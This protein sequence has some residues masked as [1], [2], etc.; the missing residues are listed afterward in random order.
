MT[1]VIPRK[2]RAIACMLAHTRAS[3]GRNPIKPLYIGFGPRLLQNGVQA[4]RMTRERYAKMYI[5]HG[6]GGVPETSA[7]AHGAGKRICM[8]AEVGNKA[9][10]AREYWMLT[11]STM[12]PSAPA[13]KAIGRNIMTDMAMYNVRTMGEKEAKA[14]M[15][16]KF[17]PESWCP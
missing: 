5:R 2:C 7:F 3:R 6:W 12:S 15:Q 13:P 11:R 17:D 16:K 8:V 4:E 10:N 9:A 14:T 1:Q